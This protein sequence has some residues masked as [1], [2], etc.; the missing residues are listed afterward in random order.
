MKFSEIRKILGIRQL[1]WG[2]KTVEK[3]VSTLNGYLVLPGVVFLFVFLWVKSQAIDF[4]QHNR[5]V[6]NLRSSQELDAR[7]NQNV[8]QARDGLLS[9]YDP[10]V[11][12]IAQLKTLQTDLKQTPTFTDQAGREELNSLLQAYIKVWQEKEQRSQKFQSHNAVLRNSLTYFP[13]AITNLVEKDT[14]SPT[15]A[16][17][18]NAL[19]RS[20]LLFNL[21][22]DD[23]LVLRIERE[24][25]QILADSTT[26]ANGAD[27]KMAI[28]H[29]RIIL[30]K[31]S[32]VNNQ[33]KTILTLP[34]TQR[35]ESLAQ[36][37]ERSYQQ[38]LN[39]TTTYRL[40]L[41]L[42]SFVLIVGFATWIILR[43]KA[44]AAATQQAEEKYRSIFENSVAGIFQTTLD[45]LYLSADRKSVV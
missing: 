37:Y 3:Q 43:L 6:I 38:A 8:L 29:A 5:Y 24:I 39:T 4:N 9:Y 10:I 1:N 42:L 25:R 13:I 18:L 28:A 17:R 21:S 34:T 36:A 45:G 19:L 2:R 16:I 32:Q 11:N 20:I 40:W 35:S 15:L 14:T 30:N 12:D 7:I 31:R 33:V 22:T 41:Y 27:L 23:E 44:A 26:A